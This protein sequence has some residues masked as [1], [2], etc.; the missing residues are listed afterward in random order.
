MSIQN[1]FVMK[2]LLIYPYCLESRIH[3]EEISA[4]PI[5]IYY[6][7]TLLKENGYDVEVLNWYAINQT[8]HKIREI[9][10]EKKPA[11]IGFSVLHA[12]RWGAIEIAR[13][14]KE[15]DSDVKV[16]FGGIGAT[17][18][19]EHFLTHFDVV[20]YVVLGEGEHP[21]LNLVKYLEAPGG[22]SPAS[23]SGLAYREGSV[24]KKNEPAEFIQDL[25]TL[26]NPARYF[27]FQH[28][29]SSRGCP[30]KCTFCGS[31]RFWKNRVR[32]HSPRYFV[33][34]LQLLYNKGVIFFYVS[35]DTFTLKKDRVIQIC[36]L[37]VERNLNITWVA[38]SRVDVLDEEMLY[39]MR[40]AGCTQISFGV[41]SGCEEIRNQILKKKIQTGQ[42]K[43]AF[44]LTTRYGILPRAYFIY[45]SPGET[46]DTI[47][48]TLALIREIK[49]LST[50][51][52]ILDIFPGTALYEDFLN[53]T[54]QSDDIWLQQ[55]E[56]ILYFETDPNLDKDMIMGFG[57]ELR[58]EFHRQL[59]EFVEAIQLEENKTLLP[60]HADFL[61]RLAMTFSHGDYAAVD[62]IEDKEAIA[63][64]LFT[65]A[66]TYGPDHRAFLGLG[67]IKQKNRKTDESIRIL[68]QGLAHYP[69]SPHLNMCLGINFMNKAMFEKA[70]DCFQKVPQRQGAEPYIA[71]CHKA[72]NR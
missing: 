35:D 28:V 6:V 53:S 15:V 2:I 29:V 31:P 45:G 14:A 55:I 13:I 3:E 37:I 33:D 65:R 16:V 11:V 47:G 57:K 72:L 23:I 58:S 62:M 70:L 30:G 7:A 56:D 67:L 21:F 38:I 27:V 39:W 18:L 24:P 41:E 9:L 51:F 8:P 12:N 71:E 17:F 20:D 54:G 63:E 64:A 42:I 32:F 1:R 60:L 26:P 66:L 36:R 68:E 10:A 49:P 59:P 22:N 61:S 5:G 48:Q 44:D 43:K 40:L 25:D 69:E 34:Q 46:H 19:W 50:I 52:Y 4:P